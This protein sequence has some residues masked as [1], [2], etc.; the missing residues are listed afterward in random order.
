MSVRRAGE[1]VSDSPSPSH[2]SH[3]TARQ[4]DD[5]LRALFSPSPLKG[6]PF[7][8]AIA[9]L[10]TAFATSTVLATA[11]DMPNIL[12]L[13]NI[14]VM[15]GL[16]AFLLAV[17]R[18][19]M[20]EAAY[21]IHDIEQQ[22]AFVATW[23]TGMRSPEEGFR[24][25]A[26][27][28]GLPR[29]AYMRQYPKTMKLLQ[30]SVVAQDRW[31]VADALKLVRSPR[32]R[33]ASLDVRVQHRDGT[34]H[35]VRLTLLRPGFP[36]LRARLI[37]GC[38]DLT[39]SDPVA[40]K[41]RMLTQI[42]DATSMRL[43]F[44]S[45]HELAVAIGAWPGRLKDAPRPLAELF[46]SPTASDFCTVVNHA[47]ERQ[48]PFL[49]L[50]TDAAADSGAREDGTL[51]VD[52]APLVENGECLGVVAVVRDVAA[53]VRSESDLLESSVDAA[54]NE[55]HLAH[56]SHEVSGL[57][58][59][60]IGQLRD[61]QR[62]LAE[63]TAAEPPV[64]PLAALAAL[65]AESHSRRLEAMV[66]ATTEY[67]SMSSKAQAPRD[68]ELGRRRPVA[69]NMEP[70]MRSSV[71]LLNRRALA[72]NAGTSPQLLVAEIDAE[73]HLA[74][75]PAGFH[76]DELVTQLL[77]LAQACSSEG[78]C[79]VISLS[80]T[81]AHARAAGD[82]VKLRIW[83]ESRM[84][85]P[86]MSEMLDSPFASLSAPAESQFGFGLAMLR[87]RISAI[88]GSLTLS[89]DQGAH[90]PGGVELVLGLPAALEQEDGFGGGHRLESDEVEHGN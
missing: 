10:L 15:G 12:R 6:S 24:K 26:E 53:H 21:R 86:S 82:F 29:E 58:S 27:W 71:D 30:A 61:A 60:V 85:S 7:L 57:I 88:G 32:A 11:S 1:S 39:A 2:P 31:R 62:H 51:L 40:L 75:V 45:S 81:P 64:A 25:F 46:P 89:N 79:A 38:L 59:E 83:V 34:E 22:T 35:V 72:A 49:Y 65:H 20:R 50:F 4:R 52:G 78:S 90:E 76:L 73:T 13:L 70:L 9:V 28:V 36:W 47:I 17:Q 56:L 84:S 69:V 54:A 87:H 63:S 3:A 19:D 23:A 55:R 74:S 16:A 43:L 33:S 18:R 37:V 5:G 66:R 8:P 44:A 41:L 42:A 48:E 14:A 67:L 68:A 77:M 80:R